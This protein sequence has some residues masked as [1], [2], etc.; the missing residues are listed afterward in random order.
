MDPNR[1]EAEQYYQ[2]GL[3]LLHAENIQEAIAAFT[4]AIDLDADFA[5][6]YYYRGELLIMS[7]RIVEAN[8]DLQKAKALRSG[9][10]RRKTKQKKQ[11]DKYNWQEVDSI[12]DAVPADGLDA[13]QNEA[14]EFDHQIYDFVFSDDT[15]ETEEL[16]DGLIGGASGRTASS[17]AILEYVGGHREEVFRS[18]LFQPSPAE[19]TILQ[20]DDIQS[21][22]VVPL[23]ELNCLRLA[24]MPA[25]CTATRDQSCLIEIVETRDGNIYHEYIPTLQPIDGVLLGFSTKEATH[26]PYTFFPLANVK[27]R[28]Q[29]R[30]L[31]DILLEKRFIA[32]DILRGALEEHSQL[33]SMQ[34]GRIIARQANIH[35]AEVETVIARAEQRGVLGLRTGEILLD[36][37]LVSEEQVLDALE[38]QEKMKGKR[39]G[40]FLV[41]KGILREKELYISL[42]EKFRLPFVDLRQQ[43]VAKKTLAQLPRELVLRHKILPIAVRDATLVIATGSPEVAEV[44]EAIH[45][46]DPARK[47][48]FVLAQPTHLKNVVTILYQDR[49]RR[50]REEG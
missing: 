13:I 5:D 1:R 9:A 33:R 34:L 35:Y 14:V 45:Q 36:T 46:H 43:K 25:G 30:Y 48:E 26:F 39:L 21:Q 41:E 10:P 29:K 31:G 3:Q 6:A 24:R 12:Y 40:E 4:K 19:I 47:V 50:N 42:A 22:R 11:I 8:A 49:R 15:L 16:W 32:D 17:P 23:R 2:L 20:E 44:R 37:G 28:Y 18:L 27:L 38:Y 7:D